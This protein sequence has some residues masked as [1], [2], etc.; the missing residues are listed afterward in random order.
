[1]ERM[2]SAWTAKRK[3]PTLRASSGRTDS[4]VRAKEMAKWHELCGILNACGLQRLASE[5][6]STVPCSNAATG[7]V[8]L[9]CIRLFFLKLLRGYGFADQV[10]GILTN[11]VHEQ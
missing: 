2:E 5:G 11:H 10:A 7:T 3:I 8:Q 6:M 9:Y 1:M 4:G